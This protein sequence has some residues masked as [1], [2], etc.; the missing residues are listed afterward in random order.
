MTDDRDDSDRVFRR[1]REEADEWEQ[2]RA[3]RRL[4]IRWRRWR[5]SWRELTEGDR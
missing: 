4:S 5:E 3:N 1:E 2:R